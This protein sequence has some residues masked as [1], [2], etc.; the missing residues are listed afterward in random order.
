[1]I[2]NVLLISARVTRLFPHARATSGQRLRRSAGECVPLCAQWIDNAVRNAA[3]RLMR[4]TNSTGRSWG[5]VCLFSGV[6]A[7]ILELE[8]LKPSG[9]R[10]GVFVEMQNRSRRLRAP[11]VGV[12]IETEEDWDRIGFRGVSGIALGLFEGR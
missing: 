7:R 10:V 2:P 1:M 8:L 3:C 6:D 12:S 4:S 11:L 5:S 9:D